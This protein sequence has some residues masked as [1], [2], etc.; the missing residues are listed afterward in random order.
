MKLV[1][2]NRNYQ[3]NIGDAF[4]VVTDKELVV[5]KIGKDQVYIPHPIYKA[6]RNKK[7]DQ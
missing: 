6:N 1:G 2:S 3:R 5:S 4:A 7:I